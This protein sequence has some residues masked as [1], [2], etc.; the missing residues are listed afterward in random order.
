M[1]HKNVT[2]LNNFAHIRI[3]NVSNQIAMFGNINSTYCCNGFH[4]VS[5]R[6]NDV[7]FSSSKNMHSYI[8]CG[9]NV[10]CR[11]QFLLLL[12]GQCVFFLH[13]TCKSNISSN[14]AEVN[15]P[16]PFSTA[17]RCCSWMAFNIF[18]HLSR[19]KVKLAVVSMY[20]SILCVI[21]WSVPS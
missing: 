16:K 13:V 9:Y 17:R 11:N 3:A 14:N 18:A 5:K 6:C 12:C 21:S 20:Q 10:F 2:Q 19:T 15:V 8:P 7:R 1:K 4:F